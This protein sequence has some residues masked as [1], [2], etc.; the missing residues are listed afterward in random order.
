MQ[1]WAEI[2]SHFDRS[3][4]FSNRWLVFFE[5][6]KDRKRNNKWFLSILIKFFSANRVVK[7]LDFVTIFMHLGIRII[8]WRIVAREFQCT[9]FFEIN[10]RIPFHIPRIKLPL[11]NDTRRPRA[12]LDRASSSALDRRGKTMADHFPIWINFKIAAWFTIAA[13]LFDRFDR[14]KKEEEK[15]KDSP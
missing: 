15:K 4:L 3:I 12:I 6:R 10:A 5:S 11:V 14:K 8:I 1:Q 9:L 2:S 7:L 13:R